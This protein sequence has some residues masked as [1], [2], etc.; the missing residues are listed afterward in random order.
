MGGKDEKITKTKLRENISKEVSAKMKSKVTNFTKNVNKSITDNTMKVSN[1]MV[2]EFKSSTSAQA[3]ASNLLEDV[4][5]MASGGAE[6]DINQDASAKLEMA[7]IVNILSSNEQ[8]NTLANKVTAALQASIKNDSKLKAQLSQAAKIEA[9]A[10]K[11]GGF[12]NM[13]GGMVDKF[14]GMAEGMMK[15]ATGG[16]SSSKSNSDTVRNIRTKISTSLETEINNT[17]INE[18]TIINKMSVD[19]KN[20]FKNMTEDECLGS[21]ESRNMMRKL[22]LLADTGAKIKVMQVAKTDAIAKCIS[23]KKIGNKALTGL[24]TDNSYKSTLDS[25]NKNTSKSGMKQK[26]TISKKTEE[27]DAINDSLDKGL[28]ELGKTSR[29]LIKEVGES[30][31]VGIK[32]AGSVAK[33]GLGVILL[34]V[35]VIGLVIMAVVIP[36]LLKGDDDMEDEDM[37][38]GFINLEKIAQYFDIPLAKRGITIIVVFIILD[39]ILKKISKKN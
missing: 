26:A 3:I 15:S 39:V 5:I 38:G 23:T 2:N 34:P 31:R 19:I 24:A 22:K 28:G 33:M 37:D 12:G 13:V 25:S 32:E 17:N 30:G 29:D 36:K 35:I 1:S 4:T 16:S 10:K 18:N 14:A 7:A 20:S 9:K 21:A 27:R 11:A 6:I 8:K